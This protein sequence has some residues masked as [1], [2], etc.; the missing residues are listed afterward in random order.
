[1]ASSSRRECSGYR[2][3]ARANLVRGVATTVNRHP[4]AAE[5]C[6][7]YTNTTTVFAEPC[8]M[9]GGQPMGETMS[10]LR[11]TCRQP[12][13]SCFRWTEHH[14]LSR[15]AIFDSRKSVSTRMLQWVPSEKNVGEGRSNHGI[16]GY[17]IGGVTVTPGESWRRYAWQKGGRG[18]IWEI[19]VPLHLEWIGGWLFFLS[20]HA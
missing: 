2:F 7:L 10:G 20:R 11:S 16:P 14:A 4:L 5:V 9:H 6:A 12:D 8:G 18:L 13:G 15:Q 3:E 19:D 17:G 1:M